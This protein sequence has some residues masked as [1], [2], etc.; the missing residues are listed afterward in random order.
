[1]LMDIDL[2]I[3]YG[4]EVLRQEPTS[5]LKFHWRTNLKRLKAEDYSI[6]DIHKIL[7][8]LER[9]ENPLHIAFLEDNNRAELTV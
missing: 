6:N 4:E 3:D 8:L 1:M 9:S 2:L 7:Y 5:A